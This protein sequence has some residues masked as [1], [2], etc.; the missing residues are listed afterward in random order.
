M[1][2]WRCTCIIREQHQ[3]F[4]YIRLHHEKNVFAALR[5]GA[6]KRSRKSCV[7]QRQHY[8]LGRR[9]SRRFMC[10]DRQ[11]LHALRIEQPASHEIHNRPG[12]VLWAEQIPGGG[13]ETLWVLETGLP[14]RERF[15]KIR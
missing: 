14:G 2:F 10:N 9:C 6:R 8:F 3:V 4:G 1:Y 12:S 13:D 11:S 15:P 7:H 5:I